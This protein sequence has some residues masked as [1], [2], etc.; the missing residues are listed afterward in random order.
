MISQELKDQ[1]RKEIDTFEESALAFEAGTAG[2]LSDLFIEQTGSS[3]R[4]FISKAQRTPDYGIADS[5]R[6]PHQRASEVSR[7]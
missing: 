5:W 3:T 4:L 2:R 6:L 7:G 1:F